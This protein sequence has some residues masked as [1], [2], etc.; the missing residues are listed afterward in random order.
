MYF[1]YQTLTQLIVSSTLQTNCQQ[2]CGV[3]VEGD[4]EGYLDG[5][6]VTAQIEISVGGEVRSMADCVALVA[7]NQPNANGAT[8]GVT[9]GDCYAEIDQ[10]CVNL[11]PYV[12]ERFCSTPSSTVT[13]SIAP[14]NS[15]TSCLQTCGIAVEGDG[16]GGWDH[17]VGEALTMAD[18][19][20][21]V[22]STEPTANGAT[23]G[24][25][26]YGYCWAEFDQDCV[27]SNPYQNV[28]FGS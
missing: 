10:D 19:V 2:T 14:T 15:P 23:W 17:Y 22:Q 21:L 20:V 7:D 3:V 24:T 6:G 9:I 18:C 25:N 16:T 11:I 12:N 13:S 28:H 27:N 5:T 8:W 1:R 4:G 26:G